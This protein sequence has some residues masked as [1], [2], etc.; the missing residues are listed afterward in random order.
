MPNMSHIRK[1]T[2]YIAYFSFSANVC[3]IF[4]HNCVKKSYISFI[5]VHLFL[6][7]R[8][9][10]VIFAKENDSTQFRSKKEYKECKEYKTIV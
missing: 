7:L 1:N 2:P 9:L 3:M 10:C 6:V 5:S 8:I 4:R